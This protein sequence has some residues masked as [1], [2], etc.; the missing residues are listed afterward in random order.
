M[1]PPHSIGTL[2]VCWMVGILY[3]VSSPS[4]NGSNGRDASGRFVR[5]N[6]GGPGNPHAAKVGKLRSAL[7]KA[8][9]QK[10]MAAV[11]AAL[12]R[13]AEAGNVTAIR[14]LLDRVLGKP[15]EADLIERIEQLEQRLAEVGER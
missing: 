2:K 10:R 5:G 12:V 14:E 15:V 8:V 1:G 6:S 11:V 4:P 3:D 7:L 9:T 13:E